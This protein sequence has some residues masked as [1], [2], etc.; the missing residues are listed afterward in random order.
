MSSRA[1]CV[2]TILSN[3][4]EATF[5]WLV[6]WLVGPCGWFGFSGWLVW[7]AVWVGLVGSAWLIRLVGLIGWFVGCYIFRLA[8]II[9]TN[10]ICSPRTCAKLNSWLVHW[11]VQLVN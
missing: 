6:G 1:Q 5:G 7:F 2:S 11:L 8:G 10:D 9:H 4:W 3:K